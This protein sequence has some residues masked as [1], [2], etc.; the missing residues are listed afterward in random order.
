MKLVIIEGPDRTGKN[1]ILNRLLDIAP[2][3]VVRHFSK[4]IGSTPI[5]QEEYQK[6]Y[7]AEELL[8]QSV[9]RSQMHRTDDDMWI[10]NRSHI[11]ESVYGPM[12]RGTHPDTWL[13]HLESA[14][15][16]KDAY[17]IVLAGDPETLVK[18]G[19]GESLAE[20]DEL[21]YHIKVEKVTEEIMRF[22]KAFN[23]C[24]IPLERK[25][26][27]NITNSNGEYRSKDDIFNEVK[28]LLNI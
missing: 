6:K 25:R 15:D 18:N 3:S 26:I 27:I 9:L 8:L 13:S 2:N 10:F 7:F 14:V 5:E 22:T 19:D 16:L 23:N 24:A 20:T 21:D 12:Y 1:T 28:E 4:P 11:G 17:L